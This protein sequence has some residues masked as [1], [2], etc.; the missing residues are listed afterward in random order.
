MGYILPP[1]EEPNE[2]IEN[3]SGRRFL[4]GYREKLDGVKDHA[5]PHQ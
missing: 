5:H 1:T 4:T 3:A 2:T